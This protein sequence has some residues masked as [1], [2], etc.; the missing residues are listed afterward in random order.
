MPMEF[1][2]KEDDAMKWAFQKKDAEWIAG[3]LNAQLGEHSSRSH[4][5]TT[6]ATIG[7]VYE[8]FRG[9]VW[10]SKKIN[11]LVAEYDKAVEAAIK[12]E[13]KKSEVFEKFR[14]DILENPE[15]LAK[16]ITA[17]GE[18]EKSPLPV[19]GEI[20]KLGMAEYKTPQSLLP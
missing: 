15:K 7:S 16:T 14:A 17:Y 20:K 3:I 4:M 9:E 13:F 19:V 1:T 5:D 11:K 10:R 12:Y 18:S 8:E 6:S 2:K